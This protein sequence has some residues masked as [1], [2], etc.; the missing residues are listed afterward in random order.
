M[1][2]AGLVVVFDQVFVLYGGW[3]VVV[4][5]GLVLLLVALVDVGWI[6]IFFFH[7]LN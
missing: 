6:G 2:V 1:M 5:V 7:I 4:V 3:V